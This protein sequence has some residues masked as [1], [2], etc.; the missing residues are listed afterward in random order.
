[1]TYSDFTARYGIRLNP[2][3][4][5]AVRKVNGSALLLAVPG[6]GKTTV[7]V[8]RVGYMIFCVGIRPENILTLTFSKAAASEMKRR[9]CDL[10][11]AD[12]AGTP[13]FS[14]IHSFCLSVIRKCETAHGLHVP[15]LMTD[16]RSVLR[17]VFYRICYQKPAEMELS[18]LS[19]CISYCKNMMVGGIGLEGIRPG[20]P[21][22]R[23][24]YEEYEEYKKANDLMDFDD[25]LLFAH[26][27][28]E[29]YPDI[30]DAVRHRY[31][32]INIDEA[33]DT[34]LIQHLIIKKISSGHGN[35]FMVGDEDQSIY[36]FRAAYPEA[37]LRF[38]K[39]HP[40]AVIM[41]L[42]TNYR[43]CANIVEAAKRI[44][45]TNSNRYDKDM[46]AVRS[47]GK[48]REK[49]L[50]DARRQYGYLV[51]VLKRAA[52]QGKE[53]AVLYR[54]NESAVPLVDLLEKEGIGYGGAVDLSYFGHVV[55]RDMLNILKLI[56]D[57]CD[58]KAYSEVYH[59]LGLY[60]SKQQAVTVS[61]LLMAEKSKAASN[62]AATNQAVSDKLISR[63]T[64]FR[65]RASSERVSKKTGS[66]G[67]I[68]KGQ[69]IKDPMSN[70][71]I[72]KKPG[73]VFEILANMETDTE[74]AGRILDF[75]KEF[76][77]L[78]KL[79]PIDAL[80][81][82]CKLF[83]HNWIERRVSEGIDSKQGLEHK[84]STL[85]ALSAG[86]GTI[87]D[88]I[89]RLEQFSERAAAGKETG[90]TK[91]AADHADK[92][93]LITL[94]TI[95]SSKGME[96]DKVILIDVYDGILPSGENPVTAGAG[97][98]GYE[99][100]TRLFYVA[101]TRARDEI[102]VVTAPR[103]FGKPL[104]R[105]PY[106]DMLFTKKT[107]TGGKRRES[108]RMA[109]TGQIGQA[110]QAIYPEQVNGSVVYGTAHNTYTRYDTDRYTAGAKLKH[111]Y[112]GE[113][114]IINRT[115]DILSVRFEEGDK[116]MLLSA[117]LK[118]GYVEL[119]D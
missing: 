32:Y 27:I 83:Y 8:A 57:P 77:K 106:T 34:S 109:Q 49:K 96:F 44:I 19:K 23:R 58:P 59:K 79:R 85:L 70:H 41:L 11:G 65:E 78:N 66:S 75:G 112:F 54:N 52:A 89:K 76:A 40:G 5:R 33:Q 68:L 92:G 114:I 99:E 107:L 117:C 67:Q 12:A 60:T 46:E 47:G 100:E 98:G 18:D 72:S 90:K 84:F 91:K 26:K 110:G 87:A 36:G 116:K 113:G 111:K 6:S 15:K 88:F 31:R 48:I 104:N 45:Q 1:M 28:L 20:E 2:Q 53:V 3:Q 17:K 37:L 119:S 94:S 30:L 21:D 73:T 16:N 35:L 95:H 86:Y 103:M 97:Y 39:D 69:V 81:A 25:Q 10:F 80:K 42:E 63:E 56:L 24:F 101:M 108:G 62:E 61:K 29:R 4:E 102:E 9:F 38:K 64:L 55:P 14:T 13:H 71:R 105:S 43:C 7:I 51:E 74:K 22:F 118:W 115:G 82:V 50:R 93:N